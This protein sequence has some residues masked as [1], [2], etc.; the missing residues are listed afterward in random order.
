MR[1]LQFHRDGTGNYVMA[2]RVTLMKE[3]DG[4][5]EAHLLSSF[6]ASFNDF[7]L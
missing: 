7:F 1:S 6:S 4:L 3:D 2:T 5:V